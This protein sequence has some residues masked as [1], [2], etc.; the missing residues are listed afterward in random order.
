MISNFDFIKKMNFLVFNVHTSNHELFYCTTG[1]TLAFLIPILNHILEQKENNID[2]EETDVKP[3]AVQALIMTPTREL[4]T[5]IH[6][7]CDKL[8]PNQCVTLVGGIAMVKQVRILKTKKPSVVIATPGRLWAMVSFLN[9]DFDIILSPKKSRKTNS[10]RRSKN[11]LV[12]FARTDTFYF[13]FARQSEA[14]SLKR[15]SLSIFRNRNLIFCVYFF[16]EFSPGIA[17]Q[18]RT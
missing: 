15:N 1:K 9:E 3:A 2:N 7:E 12:G 11:N 14:C 16:V 6:A 17:F 18:W 5:Q 8:L 4:A 10:L 13:I